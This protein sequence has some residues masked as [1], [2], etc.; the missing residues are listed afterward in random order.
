MLRAGVK[1]NVVILGLDVIDVFDF[2]H[3]DGSCGAHHEAL[4]RLAGPRRF[5]G[6]VVEVATE[7]G[8]E[9][10]YD[11]L[12]ARAAHGLFGAT[13]RAQEALVFER[14]ENIVA[15]ARVERAERVLVVRRD[16]H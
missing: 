11:V 7:K 5:G 9:L 2:D 16:E 13:E 15:C 3:R 8:A 12:H 6:I 10:L 1:E 14:L 4:E